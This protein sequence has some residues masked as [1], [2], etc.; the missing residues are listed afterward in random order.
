MC[1]QKE[2]CKFTWKR[3]IIIYSLT[4]ASLDLATYLVDIQ[5]I[6]NDNKSNYNNNQ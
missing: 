4:A 2:I 3:P 5:D 1:I 6:Q